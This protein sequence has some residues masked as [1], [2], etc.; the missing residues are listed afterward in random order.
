MKSSPPHIFVTS[1]KAV[2]IVYGKRTDTYGEYARVSY[3]NGHTWSDE[4]LIQSAP[5]G[6]LGYPC[7]TENA[8]GELVT[9]Y[10][11]KE[12]LYDDYVGPNLI[13]YTIWKL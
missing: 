12:A 5:N 11:Q 6:D 8:K 9:V 4:M 7:T 13:H 10:Y 3:D 2:V 1:N